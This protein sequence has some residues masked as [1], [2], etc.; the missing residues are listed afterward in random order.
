MA[1]RFILT[2]LLLAALCSLGGTGVASSLFETGTGGHWIAIKTG[3][4]AKHISIQHTAEYDGIALRLGVLYDPSGQ[5]VQIVRNGLVFGDPGFN[6]TVGEGIFEYDEWTGSSEQEL[7]T[8]VTWGCP[9][10]QLPAN[11]T[12]LA[13]FEGRIDMWSMAVNTVP[14]NMPRTNGTDTFHRT[15]SDF[16]SVASA[17][18]WATGNALRAAA[19]SET[20]EL[21]ANTIITYFT[22][23]LK[24]PAHF[25]EVGPNGAARCPCTHVVPGQTEP[26][27]YTYELIDL[28]GAFSDVYIIGAEV[29]LPTS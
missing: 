9:S 20:I 25:S 17:S 22:S 19:G 12:L 1:S 28:D 7:T 6:A 14:T 24:P 16:D 21:E 10:C 23:S 3:A 15:S 8:T 18:A 26:G 2:A 5:P 4:D 11:Y 13:V 27:S 29:Q